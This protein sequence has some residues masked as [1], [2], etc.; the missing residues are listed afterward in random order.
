MSVS[1]KIIVVGAGRMGRGIGLAYAL[2]GIETI[3]IDIKKRDN[4]EREALAATL[5]GELARELSF[6]VDV[7][8]LTRDLQ[9]RVARRI[10]VQSGDS[11]DATEHSIAC[12]F[13]AVPEHEDAKTQAFGYMSSHFPH[14]TLIAS[15]TSTFLVDD[16]A[17]RLSHP[18][19]FANAHWLNPAH[20]MPLVEIS[21]GSASSDEA[22]MR[23][24]KSLE[25]IGKQT[26]TCG[27]SPGYIVPRIQALAMNEAARLVEENVASAED[28]DKA[29]RTGFGVRYAILGLL[30]FIDWGG[31]DILYYASDYL[32]KTVNAERYKAPDIITEN[33][34]QGRNGLADGVGFYNY[35]DRD[36]ENYR[37]ERISSFIALLNHLNLAPKISKS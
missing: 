10:T 28:I 3:L 27:A 21:R 7:G 13:E 26:I 17:A 24:R 2:A 11:F 37:R 32:G 4:T 36:V 16:L 18:Q 30:E 15:T 12:V 34:A 19:R 1:E 25:S 14:D 23:L 5:E 8:L 35:A 9:N 6:L 33:M 29:I 22:I 31:G 20:L